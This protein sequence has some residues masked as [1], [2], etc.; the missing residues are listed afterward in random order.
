MNSEILVETDITETETLYAA[1]KLSFKMLAEQL[2]E[3]TGMLFAWGRIFYPY[4]QQEDA[5]RLIP[6]AIIKL[7]KNE[8]FLASPGEQ[9]RDYLHV[10]D[11]ASAFLALAEKQEAG[12]FNICSSQPITI[13]SGLE[14][15]GD[16]MKKKDLLV[17]G[18]IPYREWEP[19][20]IAGNNN[21]LKAIGWKPSIDL[22]FGLHDTIKWWKQELPE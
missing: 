22:R 12:V 1:S 9:I 11:V 8:V 20:H 7:L 15:I 2:C 4:G 5:R 16:L 18:A 14:L 10:T 19:M 17:Y 3:Q 21:K 6:S 13:K